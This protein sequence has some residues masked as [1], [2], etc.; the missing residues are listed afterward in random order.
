MKIVTVPK[1]NSYTVTFTSAATSGATGGGSS[2]T[3][4]YSQ[5]YTIWKYTITGWTRIHSFRS[6]I[7]IPKVRHS[8][9]SLQELKQ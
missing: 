6:S 1:A 4:K 5:Y 9:N 2:I 7:G 8:L 3:A